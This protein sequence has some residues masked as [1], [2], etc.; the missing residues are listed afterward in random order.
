MESEVPEHTREPV[1]KR[2][3]SLTPSQWEWLERQS[4]LHQTR[5]QSAE[6]RRLIEA[7]R[8]REM[9]AVAA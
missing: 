3:V 1:E 4:A 2:S 7:A 6:L 9:G 8:E 5:S